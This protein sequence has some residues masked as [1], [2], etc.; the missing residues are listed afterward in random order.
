MKD[1]CIVAGTLM[2]DKTISEL[3]LF[4]TDTGLTPSDGH[5]DYIRIA[6]C[7]S[8]EFRRGFDHEYQ[9]VGDAD[10]LD[11][12]LEDVTMVSTRLA[13]NQM[14]HSFEVYD[15]QGKVVGEFNYP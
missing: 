5:S 4:L 15:D 3:R 2:S 10:T 11:R 13:E 1:F 12:L 7:F 6:E 14:E 8:F 9:I